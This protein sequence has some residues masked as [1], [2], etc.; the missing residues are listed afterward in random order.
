MDFSRTHKK[1]ISFFSIVLPK[2]LLLLSAITLFGYTVLRANWL[3]MTHDESG[4]FYIWTEFNIFSCFADPGCWR[5]ANLH[6]L[7]VWLMKATVGLFGVSE[8]TIRMPSLFGHLLYLF[9]SYKLVKMW[10]E[11]PW[12][13]LIGFIIINS[14]PFLLEFFA[15]GRGYGL[16]NAFMMMSI[17]Y[18]GVFMKTNK[19][20]AAWGMFAGAFLAVF[21]NFTMLNYYACLVGVLG[22]VFLHLFFAAKEIKWRPWKNLL[23]V[24]IITSVIL[25]ALLY[26]PVTSL[27]SEGE[28][29]YGAKS[30][31]D[32]FSSNV[33][34][35]LYGVKYFAQYHVEILGG[36]FTLLLLYGLFIAVRDFINDPKNSKAQFA[37]AVT[38][39]PIMVALASVVQHYLLGVN[40]LRG[41]TSLVFVPLT[42]LALFFLF[43]NI[44]TKENSRLLR[45][46]P[47]VLGL[48]C[49][50]HAFRSYQ[51]T[52]S[53]EWWYDARTRDMVEYMDSIIP[54]GEKVKLG[55]H[56]IFHP[57][58]RYYYENVPYEF[59]ETLNYEKQYR[60]DVYYDYYYINPGEENK[61]NPRYK[62]LQKFP[63]VGVLMVRDSL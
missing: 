57:T 40:Y 18:V 31:W 12:L 33:K 25:F 47:V 34:T 36:L 22:I 13:Q 16:A 58:A 29:E 50:V 27:S 62:V 32:T 9:F 21:S 19:S 45:S 23:L 43:E 11:K 38:I 8:L 61:I 37:V 51:F 60:S 46:I 30:F 1:D 6:F 26:M 14:N 17:Y 42:T 28:F 56:W 44:F 4:S 20:G 41:R 35:S 10:A 39:L 49:V 7:Y 53:Y 2:V 55:M 52:H 24:G 3:S 63:W 54:K 15:L 59:T 48:F 5:T